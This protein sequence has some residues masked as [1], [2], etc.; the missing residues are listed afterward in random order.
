MDI[1]NDCLVSVDGTDFEIFNKK[2]FCKAWFSHKFRGPGVRYE[3]GLNIM[4]GDIVW[5]F[6]PCPCGSHC[7]LKIFREAMKKEL[8]KGEHVEADDGY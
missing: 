2:P 4:S 3:V 7:E 6:G 5:I 1:G 8:E